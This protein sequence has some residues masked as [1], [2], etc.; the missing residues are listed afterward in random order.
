MG[1]EDDPGFPF[2]FRSISRGELLNFQ[3]VYA[4]SVCFSSDPGFSLLNMVKHPHETTGWS[5]G[6]KSGDVPGIL[7]TTSTVE[8]CQEFE[9][10][11]V[12]ASGVRKKEFKWTRKEKKFT[13]PEI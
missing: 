10:D 13:P 4:W 6:V 8:K 1:M 12:P 7:F 9:T 11:H 2:G 3:G 5:K